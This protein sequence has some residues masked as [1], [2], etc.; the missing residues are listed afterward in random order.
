[1]QI[2]LELEKV[3]NQSDTHNKRASHVYKLFAF[4]VLVHS[5]IRNCLNVLNKMTVFKWALRFEIPCC[6][7]KFNGYENYSDFLHGIFNFSWS[8]LSYYWRFKLKLNFNI[9]WSKINQKDWD[10]PACLHQLIRSEHK[11]YISDIISILKCTDPTHL[12]YHFLLK[13]VREC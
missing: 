12:F 9:D 1:M 10:K 11:Y 3:H 2:R 5:A 7:T 13:T 8:Y 4:I 6:E